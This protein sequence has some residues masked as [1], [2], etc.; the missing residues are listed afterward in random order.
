VLITLSGFLVLGALLPCVVLAEEKQEKLLTEAIT[1][2]QSQQTV[3][4]KNH[5]LQAFI[6]EVGTRIAET[7]QTY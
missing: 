5:D 2:V 4:L 7:L 6:Y 1:L 3:L